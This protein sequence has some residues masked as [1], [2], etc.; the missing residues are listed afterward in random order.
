MQACGAAEDPVLLLQVQDREFFHHVEQAQQAGDELREHSC[1]TSTGHTHSEV[2][3]AENVEADIQQ[4]GK[5]KKIERRFAVAQCAQDAGEQ[6]VENVGKRAGKDDDDVV[7]CHVDNV[8]RRVHGNKQRAAHGHA[9]RRHHNA[10][11]NAQQDRHGHRVAHAVIVARA[12]ALRHQH[13]EAARHAHDEAE[14]EERQ[15]TRG[16]DGRQRVHAEELAHDDGVHHAVK[17]LKKVAD[18]QRDRKTHDKLDGISHGHIP[19]HRFDSLPFL[20]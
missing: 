6:I 2:H 8:I 13:G 1:V 9:Q 11:H 7:I 16:A 14:N 12:E 18:Q 15:R 4:G 3:N 19:C 20:G 17:L 5:D 10:Q